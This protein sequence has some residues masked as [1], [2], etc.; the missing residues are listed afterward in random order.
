MSA[1]KSKSLTQSRDNSKEIL[2]TLKGNPNAYKS[3]GNY[4]RA[5]R[6]T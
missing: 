6:Y 2:E 3:D 4:T 1:D 5:H